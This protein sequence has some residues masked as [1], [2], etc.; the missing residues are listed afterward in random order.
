MLVSVRTRSRADKPFRVLMLQCKSIWFHIY[1]FSF[2]ILEAFFFHSW[3]LKNTCTQCPESLTLVPSCTFKSEFCS[4]FWGRRKH[5]G[6]EVCKFRTGKTAFRHTPGTTGMMSPPFWSPQTDWS[7]TWKLWDGQLGKTPPGVVMKLVS[8]ARSVA[9]TLQALE[10]RKHKAK[11]TA[12]AGVRAG[13][14]SAGVSL[15]PT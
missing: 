14:C 6:S 9:D 1:Q 3:A 15:Q 10:L 8:P 11:C 7:G 12:A 2:W 5:K 4:M 13:T